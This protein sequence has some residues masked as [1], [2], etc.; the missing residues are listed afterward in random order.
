[1]PYVNIKITKEGA[2]I[3]QKAV[4]IREE[5]QEVRPARS[6]RGGSLKE[7]SACEIHVQS[8][9]ITERE[10]GLSDRQVG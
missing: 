1:M 7:C 2:T 9:H 5:E 3:E 8:D 4:L 6:G 10:S